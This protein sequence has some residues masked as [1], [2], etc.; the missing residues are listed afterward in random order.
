M[1]EQETPLWRGLSF[2]TAT[3]GARHRV[4]SHKFEFAFQQ[5]LRETLRHQKPKGLSRGL[6]PIEQYHAAEDEAGSQIV[7]K[8][9][10][11]ANKN[12]T[13]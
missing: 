5:K 6:T 3:Y 7:N 1:K 9:N 11:F 12:A 2:F 8:R 4:I 13:N 10:G